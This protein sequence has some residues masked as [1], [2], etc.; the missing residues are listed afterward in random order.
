MPLNL[1]QSLSHLEFPTFHPLLCYVK[2]QLLGK[3]VQREH[4]EGGGEGEG[5]SEALG[6]PGVPGKAAAPEK[7]LQRELGNACAEGAHV[8]FSGDAL[9]ATLACC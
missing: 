1:G 5:V 6:R 3:W 4:S 7:V 9:P 2:S 8:C